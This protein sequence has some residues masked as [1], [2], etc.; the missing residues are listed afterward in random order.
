[1]LVGHLRA[2]VKVFT[3]VSRKAII[4]ILD[5]WLKACAF[6]CSTL[7]AVISVIVLRFEDEWD[8]VIAFKHLS[9]LNHLF[10]QNAAGKTV[11]SY[12]AILNSQ[13]HCNW[14]HRWQM[15]GSPFSWHPVG[16]HS[17]ARHDWTLHGALLWDRHSHMCWL[18]ESWVSSQAHWCNYI[19]SAGFILFWAFLIIIFILMSKHEKHLFVRE[20]IK[21]PKW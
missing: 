9:E 6:N 15:Y 2:F 19:T 12:G 5:S 16:M 10:L 1:M 21:A 20:E 14:D 4:W 17:W 8:V 18:L 7:S 3:Q 11:A 13:I